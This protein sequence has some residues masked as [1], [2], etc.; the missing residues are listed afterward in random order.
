M[1]TITE[2]A[3][4]EIGLAREKVGAEDKP[5]KIMVG[6]G[7]CSGGYKYGLGFVEGTGEEETV[8]ESQGIK[9]IVQNQDVEKLQGTTIDFVTNEMGAGFRVDN[10]NPAPEGGG[11]CG[12]GDSKGKSEGGGCCGSEKPASES[13]E[14][15]C[16]CC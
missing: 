3:A 11:G 2:T 1:I 4:K 5:L 9:I 13:K 7:G 15:G 6:I 8:V 10:P 14:G 12:C 16:G